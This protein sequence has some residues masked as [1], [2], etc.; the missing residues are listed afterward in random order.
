M[1]AALGS[2]LLFSVLAFATTDEWSL[3]SLQSGIFAL[4]IWCAIRRS[5]RCHPLG[6]ALAG[7]V[8]YGVCQL[9]MGTAV[10]PFATEKALIGWAA[11]FVLFVVAL[12]ALADPEIRRKFL[13]SALYAGFAIGVL[14]TVQYFTSGGAI[15]WIFQP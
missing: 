5:L 13:Q 8:V 6:F 1:A 12:Q 3:S 4:G 7:A 2:L 14:S 11:Y 10:Y 15:Y 9:L